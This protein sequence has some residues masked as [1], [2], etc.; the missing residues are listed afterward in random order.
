MDVTGYSLETKYANLFL[1]DNHKSNEIIFAVNFDGNNTRTYGGTTFLVH[2]AVGGSMS[3]AAYGVDGGWGGLRTTA[4]LVDKFT[5]T[6]DKR[7][8][9]HTAG[10]TK[11]IADIGEFTNGYAIGNN[12]LG[13]VLSLIDLNC[14]APIE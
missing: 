6:A 14:I 10:Q 1:A 12:S 2:A 11:A 3:A 13:V 9:F 8:I 4:A 7:G 5:D